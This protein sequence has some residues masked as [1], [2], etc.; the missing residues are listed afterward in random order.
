MKNELKLRKIKPENGCSQYWVV[1]WNGHT[2][3][4]EFTSRKEAADLI[5]F[6]NLRSK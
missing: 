3:P 2:W 4:E 1:V 6:C 5:K